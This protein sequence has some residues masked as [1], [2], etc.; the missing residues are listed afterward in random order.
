MAHPPH[1]SAVAANPDRSGPETSLEGLSGEDRAAR[2]ALRADGLN[3][4][5]RG[6][7][8]AAQDENREEEAAIFERAASRLRPSWSEADQMLDLGLANA[9]LHAAPE[10]PPSPALPVVEPASSPAVVQST[11]YASSSEITDGFSASGAKRANRRY[12]AIAA[13]AACVALGAWAALAGSKPAPAPVASPA[14]VAPAPDPTPAPVEPAPAPP[15]RKAPAKAELTR[16]Q[17]AALLGSRPAAKAVAKKPLAKPVAAKAKAPLAKGP[18]A[19]AKP[20]PAK[21]PAPK[22]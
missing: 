20:A 14:V 19:K 5:E 18:A 10:Q 8:V 17:A 12:I 3:A 13:A 1:A 6:E 4:V 21:K 22:R 11:G 16:E 9:M 7:L 2:E 15:V